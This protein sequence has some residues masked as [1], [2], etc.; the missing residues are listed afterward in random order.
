MELKN[1]VKEIAKKILPFFVLE[2]LR[3]LY[4][5]KPRKSYSQN[6]EDLI[7]E[8]IFF[9]LGIKNPGYIDIGA[10]HPWFINN[11]YL[12]YK[13]G[14]KGMC[15]EPDPYLFKRLKK[16]RKNDIC[17]NAGIGSSSQ[18]KANYYITTSK[19]LNT[20]SE[21]EANKI[22][23]SESFGK[24]KIEKIIQIPLISIN[25]INEKYFKKYGDFVSID[26]EG[27]D[28]EILKSFDFLKFRPKVLCVETACLGSD[29]KFEKEQEIIDFMIRQDY[30]VYADTFIN[31]IFIDKSIWK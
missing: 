19:T 21:E 31:T 10:N 29:N 4:L 30:F 25:E 9:T 2:K 12:F 6:G 23:N 16:A 13:K 7:V 15:V 8:F 22:K 26:T 17:L 28:L 27:Y 20:F 1:K 5:C 18:E 3:S 11:T 24:Q 14:S